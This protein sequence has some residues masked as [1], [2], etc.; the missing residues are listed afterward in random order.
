MDLFTKVMKVIFVYLRHR[1]MKD[2]FVKILA[3][4]TDSNP[5][6][7]RRQLIIVLSISRCLLSLCKVEEIKLICAKMFTI[8]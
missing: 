4:F 2:F 1:E 7:S 3:I 8:V 6:T 5:R